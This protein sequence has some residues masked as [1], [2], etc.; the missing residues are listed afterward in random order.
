VASD[1]A[2]EHSDE[3]KVPATKTASERP[4]D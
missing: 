3:P 4:S 2:P 1:D